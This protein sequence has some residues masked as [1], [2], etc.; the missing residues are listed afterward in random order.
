[1]VSKKLTPE[2]I[3]ANALLRILQD[4]GHSI[5]DH[6]KLSLPIE[7]SS[8]TVYQ[9]YSLTRFEI[10]IMRQYVI[11]VL[12]IPLVDRNRRFTLL[13]LH[14][15][16]IPVPG[17]HLQ[18]QYAFLP[19]YLAIDSSGQYVAYPTEEEILA[20]SITRGGFCELNTAI[21]PTVNLQTYETAL[22]Q[23]NLEQT[24]KHPH[25]TKTVPCHYDLTIGM[26]SLGNPQSYISTVSEAHH[27]SSFTSQ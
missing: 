17:T 6:P 18:V 11:G 5:L 25:P 20:C 26:S 21:L 27:T 19:K 3:T 24:S 14:N 4:V 23:K 15:L 2:I 16:P 9:Y 13:Q 10:T 7:L 12:E 1:M 8:K 22:Y